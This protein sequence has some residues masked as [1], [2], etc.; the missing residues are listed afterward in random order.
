MP[1]ILIGP[2]L[3]HLVEVERLP[4]TGDELNLQSSI[5]RPSVYE[6]TRVG[7]NPWGDRT[8]PFYNHRRVRN[9]LLGANTLRVAVL[10]S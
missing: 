7:E 5:L 1:L 8:F 6:V 3:P 10:T 2:E 9:L 4:K